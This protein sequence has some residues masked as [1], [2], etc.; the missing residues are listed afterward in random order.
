MITFDDDYFTIKEDDDHLDE[1][2]YWSDVARV[3]YYVHREYGYYGSSA[4]RDVYIVI[5]H[6]CGDYIRIPYDSK[7]GEMFDS[8]VEKYLAI[9]VKDHK[10]LLKDAIEE[11]L[12]D[13]YVRR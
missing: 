4:G 12:I 11:K 8:N 5:E 10:S 1:L 6:D 2:Y 9:E 13:F 7:D 3:A